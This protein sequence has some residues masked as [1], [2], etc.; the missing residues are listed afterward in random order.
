MNNMLE[1]ID[2]IQ[3]ADDELRKINRH[4]EDDQ[5]EMIRPMFLALQKEGSI[6]VGQGP[7]GLGKTYVIAATAKALVKS[8]KRVC[9]AVPT[10]AHLKD[11]MMTH[12]DHLNEPYKI[13]RGLSQ[14]Q[15]PQEGCPLLNHRRPTPIF[16]NTSKTSKTGPESETCENIQCTVRREIEEA[17]QSKL[18]LTVY[19]KL[20]AQPD[21]LNGFDVVIFDE[22][23]GLEAA[24][25]SAR[26]SKVRV[27][28]ITVLENFLQETPDKFEDIKN[29][30]GKLEG[31]TEIPLGFIERAIID[32]IRE[33]LESV[34]AKIQEREKNG[35][36]I[37]LDVLNAFYSLQASTRAIEKAGFHRFI[38]H[39][40]SVLAIPLQV[41]FQ[42]YNAKN[43][44]KRLSIGLISATI[45][46]PKLHANDSG[47]PYHSLAAP[48]V[49]ESPRITKKFRNRPI[50]GLI[51]GPVL[52]K[53]PKSM[54]F[55]ELA[56]TEADKILG[57]ILPLFQEPVLILCRNKLDARSIE[58]HLA[59]LEEIKK[60]LY[61]LENEDSENDI[62]RVETNINKQI[63]LGRNI[64]LTTASSK[65][66]EGV[67]LKRLKLLVVD[68]LPYA[69]PEP[70]E[71]RESGNWGSWKTSRSFRFMIRRLQQGIG[72]L[73][74]TDDDL[75]GVVIVID[76]RFYSQWK[77]IKSALP[78]HM[79]NKD[80]IKFIPREKLKS[81]LDSTVD[82]LKKTRR[83]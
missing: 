23:H 55:Y 77:T 25:R 57:T 19:H 5:K 75:W 1:E 54:E 67:N 34:Q 58:Q 70:Y 61:L 38:A 63:D 9:I 35:D 24:V 27:D 68:S 65:I 11:V 26:I 48:V 47:F 7:T 33:I 69:M 18:V 51:D 21:L 50:I 82:Q 40:R 29:S 44:A 56:R 45:E 2:P 28:D 39:E 17:K 73:M 60:R 20:L 43:S 74:R 32:P 83:E 66:W 64:I 79:T 4:L 14:L 81:E 49:L 42:I 59:S 8:G 15:E 71:R 36:Q 72:R 16:C 10:Y 22:S 13:I 41:T 37:P 53:D 31:L 3:L 46:N 12:L 76:G 30:L 78:T 62:D 52:K 80:I 6:F